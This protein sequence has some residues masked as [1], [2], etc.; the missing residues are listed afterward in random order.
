MPLILVP[1][2]K[3]KPILVG[4]VWVNLF[5]QSGS[6]NNTIA[7]PGVI[8]HLGK[9]YYGGSSGGFPIVI[10]AYSGIPPSGYGGYE[11]IWC[12]T[13]ESAAAM[14]AAQEVGPLLT[15]DNSFTFAYSSYFNV[16]G[17][18]KRFRMTR[19]GLMCYLYLE[20]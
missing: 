10:R 9:D 20:T 8:P 3:S 18:P 17:V 19:S 4:E 15:A 7:F 13:S 11:N 2:Y 1:S 6:G 14:Q 16:L 12:L 5:F